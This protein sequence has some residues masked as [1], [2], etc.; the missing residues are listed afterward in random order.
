MPPTDPDHELRVA[1]NERARQLSQAYDDLVPI[2][3]LREGFTFGGERVS[4]GSFYSGIYRAA[5]QVGPAALTLVTSAASPYEDEIDE[6]TGAIV[7]AYRAGSLEHADNRALNA[8]FDYQV[9]LI[10]FKGVEVGQY[11]VVQPVFVTDRDPETRMVLLEPGLPLAD[12]TGQGLVTPKPVRAVALREVKVRLDQ[13]RFRREV[14]RAYRKRCTVCALKR[15]EL[16]QAA[17]IVEFAD[18]GSLSEVGNGLALCAIH[19]LA[20]DRNVLGIDPAGVVHI[21]KSVLEEIDGPMLKAGLQGFHGL[22]IAQPRSPIDR[23]DPE[24]LALRFDRF[25]AEAA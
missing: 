24:R 9:P 23:P 20:Y 2:A 16:V 13:H 12:M 7:Y 10:Y 8:A 17:H 21:A 1:A 25:S 14:M 6:E 4:F 5:K 3:A 15:P 18:P 11:A 19:H 22:E